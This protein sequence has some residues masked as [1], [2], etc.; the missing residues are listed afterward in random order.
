MIGE[1]LYQL[2]YQLY[3]QYVFQNYKYSIDFRQ[4]YS[5]I[6][7]SIQ[8][9]EPLQSELGLTYP[10]FSSSLVLDYYYTL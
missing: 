7:K 9:K 4:A 6:H 5:E 8:A 2:N 1:Y 3:Q 10:Y